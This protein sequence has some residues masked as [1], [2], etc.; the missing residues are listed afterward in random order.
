MPV[1][2]ESFVRRVRT[3][4]DEL[5]GVERKL[6]E[7]LLE[8]P[9]ELA[10]YAANE[11]AALAEVSPSTVSRFI[12]HVG[13]ASYEEARRLVREEKESGAPLFQE[14]R[15]KHA[16]TNIAVAHYEQSQR[17]LKDTF[18]RLDPAELSEMV[19]AIVAAQKVLIFGTRSSHGFATY[20]RWQIIQV[21]P[22]VIAIPGPGETS[23]EYMADIDEH[24]CVIVFG[25][26]R[27]TRQMSV[28]LEA[29]A[30][31]RSKLIFISDQSSSDF[32]K[33][34]WSIQCQCR[35]P[36]ILDNHVSVMAVCDVLATMVVDASGKAGR[37]RMATIE[38]AH[39]A[40]GEI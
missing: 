34:T 27:Q 14:S 16:A 22:N 30:R 31:A 6:A 3:H 5:S 1:P 25:V 37:K 40:A 23:S 8:F 28:V 19:K 18:D 20:L 13:F 36:G 10:S 29:A 38:M 33:A 32:A 21:L 24:D 17:N 12:R 7:F 11:L 15:V 26:R 39:D 4:L 2:A 35:A 9:G